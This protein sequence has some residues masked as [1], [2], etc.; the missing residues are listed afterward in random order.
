ML[1]HLFLITSPP[2]SGKTYWISSLGQAVQ[3]KILV[4]SPLRA[5]RDECRNKWN[6]QII[7]MTP[8]EWMMGKTF[9]DVVVFDEF[10]L[11]FYWGDTF[12]PQIWEAFFEISQHAST[13]FLLTA[14]FSD[15]MRDEIRK[16]SS[17][18][19]EIIWFNHGNLT[20][21]FPPERY[22]QVP[23]KAWM[24]KE[25]ERVNKGQETNLVFCQ[26]RDE[27]FEIA[28][29]LEAKGY[30]CLTCVGGESRQMAGKL[31]LTPRPDFIL[32]TTVLSHGV[33][34][35]AISKIFL[36]YKIDNKDF[37]IQ[38]VARGGRR[39]ESFKVF[40]LEP[41]HVIKWSFWKN[42]LAVSLLSLRQKFSTQ[43]VFL[44]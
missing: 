1:H 18:F 4:I 40:A 25:M 33:N 37:W 17:H 14:T 3:A 8:E 42:F 19:D 23:S 39:G 29:V 12:R 35:P 36:T 9:C 30:V 20:L 28:K 41:P 31:H 2:A 34:L 22:L 6:E 5:L 13:V 15:Q 27:V 32:S 43:Q 11:F 44:K 16:F 7:V 24:R 38:M 10:H 21:K 26:Y